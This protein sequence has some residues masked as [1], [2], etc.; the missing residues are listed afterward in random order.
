M[1]P[2]GYYGTTGV[3]SI[4]Q[5][6]RVYG[7]PRKRSCEVDEEAPHQAVGGHE[8]QG[9][10]EEEGSVTDQYARATQPVVCGALL[11][12]GRDHLRHDVAAAAQAGD[13]G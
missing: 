2:L 1:V 13:E 6:R 8:G 11:E 9:E 4:L 3:V 7:I 5:Y 12:R 10:G